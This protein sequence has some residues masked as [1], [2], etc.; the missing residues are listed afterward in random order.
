MSVHV[1][2]KLLPLAVCVASM[3]WGKSQVYERLSDGSLW[4][5]TGTPCQ[6]NV[7]SGWVEV[8]SGNN[9]LY[10]ASGG[11]A[12]YQV[13]NDFSIWKFVGPPC[14]PPSQGLICA[15]WQKLDNNPTTAGIFVGGDVVYQ[16]HIDG[17]VWM[18]TGQPCQGNYCPGWKQFGNDAD[19]LL[20]WASAADLVELR[21]DGKLLRYQGG[22]FCCNGW[23]EIDDSPQIMNGAS[24]LGGTYQIRN[25]G[26]IWHFTGSPTWEMLDNNANTIGIVA[27]WNLYQM[28]RNHSI[29]QYTNLPCDPGGCFGWVMIDANPSTTAI[30]AGQGTVYQEHTNGEIW[31]YTGLTCSPTACAGWKK[32]GNKPG[33]HL[34]VNQA[35]YVR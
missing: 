3:S 7:C 21:Q 28:H 25:N 20:Y 17:S 31:Q 12:L 19:A 13:R 4:E 15:G 8:D 27:D 18:S 22:G 11:G 24:G 9:T 16:V 33:G 5:Y 35:G 10:A 2:R 14:T 30:S 6:G 32:I 23:A 29:W 34:L 1:L 26:S